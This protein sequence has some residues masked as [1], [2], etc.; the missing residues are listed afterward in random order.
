MC[1]SVPPLLNWNS[2]STSEG[3]VGA[4]ASGALRFPHECDR[5]GAVFPLSRPTMPSA[6]RQGFR[7]PDRPAA[8]RAL[9]S[10][11]VRRDGDE[12]SSARKPRRVA[13]VASVRDDGGFGRGS[14]GAVVAVMLARHHTRIWLG[15][16]RVINGGV[17]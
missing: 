17:H 8:D 13:V 1:G 5:C 9:W 6:R 4:D 14:G 11:R 15:R 16:W 7:P 12:N 2:V 10:W 3:Y